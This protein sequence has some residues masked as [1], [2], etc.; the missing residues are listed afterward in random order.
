M[1]PVNGPLCPGT[2]GCSLTLMGCLAYDLLWLMGWEY[3]H[4]QQ[5]GEVPWVFFLPLSDVCYC[6]EYK[7]GLAWWMKRPC[8][9]QPTPSYICQLE[10]ATSWPQIH[11]RAQLLSIIPI[12]NQKGDLPI[13]LC[14]LVGKLPKPLRFEWRKRLRRGF[15][16]TL[17]KL[18]FFTMRIITL[19]I[20]SHLMSSNMHN[21]YMLCK[22]ILIHKQPFAG[23]A[24]PGTGQSAG[25]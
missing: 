10:Q 7:P 24:G 3:L 16:F 8:L 11:Q 14:L 19:I 4:K 1:V 9:A 13:S 21:C 12:W 20:K 17:S 25:V 18:F 5:R 23:T 6:Y 22:L 15:L 2:G